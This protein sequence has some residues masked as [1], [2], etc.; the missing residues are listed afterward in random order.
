MK[1]SLRLKKSEQA[2]LSTYRKKL[3]NM[4]PQRVERMLIYGSKARGNGGP[5]SDLDILLIVRN[6]A[7]A[8]KRQLRRMGYLLAGESDVVPSILAYTHDEWEQ[9]K[10]SGSPFRQSVERDEVRVL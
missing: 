2:W 4:R 9:R 8:Q 6:E 7:Q 5:D 3:A 10:K 1:K